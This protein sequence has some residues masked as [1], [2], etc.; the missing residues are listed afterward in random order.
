MLMRTEKAKRVEVS[1]G[2]F[3]TTSSA[4]T[5]RT[6]ALGYLGP[7][8]FDEQAMLAYLVS[9]KNGSRDKNGAA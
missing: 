4:S 5:T 3:D 6:L 7:V 2:V 9:G 8:Q 1:T